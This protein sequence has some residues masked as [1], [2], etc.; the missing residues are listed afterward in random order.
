MTLSFTGGSSI[1]INLKGVTPGFVLSDSGSPI[2]VAVDEADLLDQNPDKY[3]F[4]LLSAPDVAV[5]FAIGGGSAALSSESRCESGCTA[6]SVTIESKVTAQSTGSV[7][8]IV[9]SSLQSA[10]GQQSWALQYRS[11]SGDLWNSAVLPATSEVLWRGPGNLSTSMPATAWVQSCGSRVWAIQDGYQLLYRG[12]D[13]SLQSATQSELAVGAGVEATLVSDLQCSA[14][15]GLR[16]EG[17]VFGINDFEPPLHAGPVAANRF[18][19]TLSGDGRVIQRVVQPQEF[20]ILEF[21][22]APS[23]EQIGFCESARSAL[24]R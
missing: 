1:V 13:A 12:G 15:G 9:R 7:Y 3:P 4:G 24:G 14:N 17:F 22:E 18:S 2:A 6:E 8:Q 23:T 20:S 21:C 11:N 10:G 19:L 16:N 5:A